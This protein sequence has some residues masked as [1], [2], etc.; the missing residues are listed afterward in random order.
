MNDR[1]DDFLRQTKI[2]LDEAEQRIDGATQTRLGAVR[3]EAL[4]AAGRSHRPIWLLPAGGLAVAATVAILTVS[5]WQVSPSVDSLAA[6]EDIALLSG[7]ADPEF[8]ADL[9]FY[10]WIAEGAP[11]EDDNG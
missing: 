7:E 8:Y 3:R 2:T 11:T 9:E 5:L 10:A 6:L 1:Q 4:A